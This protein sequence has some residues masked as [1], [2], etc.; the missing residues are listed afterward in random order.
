MGFFQK[1]QSLF[2]LEGGRCRPLSLAT[3]AME[4][5]MF[6]KDN[7]NLAHQ[8]FINI[9]LYGLTGVLLFRILL[10]CFR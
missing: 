2:L 10:V 3:F 7:I 6:G 5:G 8:P 1:Q 9:L 4:V